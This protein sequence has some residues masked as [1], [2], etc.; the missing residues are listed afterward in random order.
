VINRYDINGYFTK[1]EATEDKLYTT[2]KSGVSEIMFAQTAVS[3]LDRLTAVSDSRDAMFGVVDQ[4]VAMAGARFK[5]AIF[6]DGE[7]F[8][9]AWIRARRRTCVTAC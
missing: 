2:V 6:I 8:R 4:A 1:V 7:S 5:Y 3:L 9:S